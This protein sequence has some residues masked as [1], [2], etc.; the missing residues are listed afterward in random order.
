MHIFLDPVF[1]MKKLARGMI[2]INTS[3][4]AIKGLVISHA[5]GSNP[6]LLS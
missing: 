1:F 4:N 6:R 5:V 3:M 2:S